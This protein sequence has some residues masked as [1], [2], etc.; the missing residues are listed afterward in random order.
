MGTQWSQIV[1][2][3]GKRNPGL[4]D[5]TKCQSAVFVYSTLS[6]ISSKNIIAL[7]F[8]SGSASIKRNIFHIFL[9]VTGITFGILQHKSFRA[10]SMKSKCLISGL[11]GK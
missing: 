11:L 4:A 2:E 8:K 5:Y 6:M 7:C 10:I 3:E 1:K 9:I